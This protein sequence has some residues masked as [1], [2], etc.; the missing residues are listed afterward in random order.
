[1]YSLPNANQE[2]L[3]RIYCATKTRPDSK[4]QVLRRAP[5]LCLGIKREEQVS[6]F[7]N[8]A[9]PCRPHKACNSREWSTCPGRSYIAREL[10]LSA[11]H[12]TLSLRVIFSVTTAMWCPR[13]QQ[14]TCGHT[15]ADQYFADE[16]TPDVYIMH[17]DHAPSTRHRTSSLQ[18]TRTQGNAY[19]SSQ[20]T[21]DN[22]LGTMI[23]RATSS[24]SRSS[25]PTRQSREHRS[26]S[27]AR[28]SQPSGRDTR[29]IGYL[30]TPSLRRESNAR[31]QYTP[32]TRRESSSRSQYHPSGRRESSSRN[33]YPPTSRRESSSGTQYT[34]ST[35]RTSSSEHMSLGSRYD[36]RASRARYEQE[37]HRRYH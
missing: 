35:R 24:R 15:I 18:G 9:M 1:M 28:E 2:A 3:P 16:C 26:I 34:P 6:L 20:R 12:L 14:Y 13:R 4:Q 29:T 19:T 21:C 30:R 37:H 22:S 32:P 17:C 8:P 5:M 27:V 11:A 7:R 25:E 10:A 33:Q 36:P 23:R 31:S